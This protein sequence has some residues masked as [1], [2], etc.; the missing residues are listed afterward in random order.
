MYPNLSD[1]RYFVEIAQTGN[2]S[3]AALRLGVTQPTLSLALNRLEDCVGTTLFQRSKKGVSLTPAGRNLLSQSRKL[4]QDWEAIQSKSLASHMEV[5]GLFTV[6]CHPSVALYSLP[7]CLPQWMIQYPELQ[8]SLVHDLSR[9]ILDGIVAVDID[10][11]VVVNPVRHPDLVIKTICHDEVGFWISSKKKNVPQD[12]LICDPELIQ[13]QDLL[14]K[15]KKS[16][17]DLTR[18]VRTS[19]L[20][21]V[22]ELTG[23]GAGIGII[24]GRV[25]ARYD[26]LQPVK[27]MPTFK[28]EICVVYRAE[29][30]S[31]K[32]VQVIAEELMKAVNA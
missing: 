2:V 16:G 7:Q 30:R 21:V 8:I 9:K 23:A 17:H 11:G 14:R 20:E 4:I 1:L 3:Q 27:G 29:S 6:G 12:V 5:K 22:A 32:A 28:D 19:N 10:I 15:T 18:A 13:T 25:A 26:H 31:V 24:P